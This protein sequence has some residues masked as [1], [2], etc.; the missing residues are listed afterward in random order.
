MTIAQQAYNYVKRSNCAAE[1][2]EVRSGGDVIGTVE[3]QKGGEWAV[4]TTDTYLVGK[5]GV[6]TRAG[7]MLHKRILERPTLAATKGTPRRVYAPAPPAPAATENRKDKEMRVPTLMLAQMTGNTHI[8]YDKNKTLC[9]RKI[10]LSR[11]LEQDGDTPDCPSCLSTRINHM[12]FEGGPSTEFL[13]GFIMNLAKGKGLSAK[14]YFTPANIT[15]YLCV[16]GV[17][18]IE[19][20]KPALDALVADGQLLAV[21]GTRGSTRYSLPESERPTPEPVATTL[22]V[23]D[24]GDVSAGSVGFTF[25]EYQQEETAKVL[26]LAANHLDAGAQDMVASILGAD[27]TDDKT[28]ESIEMARRAQ[29]L[30]KALRA[31]MEMTG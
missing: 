8:T 14:P 29:K 22:L 28:M 2:F 18:K 15:P 31:Y 7:Q 20:I 9:G 30:A 25:E 1:T 16:H 27:L 19:V 3:K 12:E 13:M 4:R 11:W 26:T 21:P 6:H 17:T 10:E 5:V 24:E 23:E